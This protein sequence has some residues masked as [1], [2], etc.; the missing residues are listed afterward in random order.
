MIDANTYYLNEHMSETTRMLE[1]ENR[2]RYLASRDMH[3]I[4]SDFYPWTADRMMEALN[5]ASV[6]D[7]EDMA[8]AHADDKKLANSIRE[9]VLAYWLQKATEYFYGIED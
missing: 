6:P 9:I 3:H 8:S 2:A 7:L 4:K 5:E 1:K